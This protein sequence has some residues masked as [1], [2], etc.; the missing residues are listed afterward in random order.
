MF[1][2]VLGLD[3]KTQKVLSRLFSSKIY[4]KWNWIWLDYYCYNI[5]NVKRIKERKLQKIK[6]TKTRE[7][8]LCKVNKQVRERLNIFRKSFSC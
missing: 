6:W 4:H 2:L 5:K 3:K 8:I 1:E 7:R